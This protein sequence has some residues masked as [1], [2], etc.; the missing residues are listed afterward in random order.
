V[1]FTAATREAAHNN[2]C[3]RLSKEVFTSLRNVTLTVLHIAPLVGHA[4]AGTS[5]RVAEFN[6]LAPELFF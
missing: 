6:L 1:N 4:V 2:G 5:V 3:G